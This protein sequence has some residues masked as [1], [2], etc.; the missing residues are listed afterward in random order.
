MSKVSAHEVGKSQQTFR[1]T[2]PH[3]PHGG[4]C[5]WRPVGGRV[6]RPAHFS[7]RGCTTEQEETLHR[8]QLGEKVFVLLQLP[9][10]PFLENGGI[11]GCG[12]G[13]IGRLAGR[14][15]ERQ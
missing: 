6:C 15:T 12:A 10:L 4:I 2:R 14:L 3:Q 13:E 7:Y 1:R 11:G 8:T 5:T 9:L